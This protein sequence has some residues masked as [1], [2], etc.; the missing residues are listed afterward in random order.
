MATVAASVV[1]TDELRAASAEVASR[2]RHVRIAHEQIEGYAQSLPLVAPLAAPLLGERRARG[3]AAGYWL[4]LDA[5]NFGSGWF[6]TLRK[7]AGGTGYRTVADGI[8][9]RFTE[10]GCWS[11]EELQQLSAAEVAGV[12]AQD[13]E[14]E[15]M[16][17]Y[18]RSLNSLGAHLQAECGGSPEELITAAGGSAVSL[19]TTL[20]GWQCFD[21]VSHYD[22]LELPFLKRAQ[23]LAADL[24]R[25]EVA[26]W[27]DVGALTM[28]ADNLLP[29]V[30]RL[31]GILGFDDQLVA[32]IESGGLLAH[33][34]LTEVEIRAC[35]VHAVELIVAASPAPVNAAAIDQLLWT[36]GQDRAYKAR[37]RHRSRCTAY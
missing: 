24:M 10:R 37:P 18:A 33:G 31:D 12:L 35:A 22:E 21:D 17:L 36:R 26:Q 28:F 20:A 14:H 23:I 30:L 27:D 19:I 2:A 25:A 29:H 1:V 7:G 16:A 9:R 11:A 6:P 34:S 3:E 15:L 5:I 32:M 13:P 8:R 4:T